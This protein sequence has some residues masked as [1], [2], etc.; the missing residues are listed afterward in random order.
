MRPLIGIVAR[1]NA[2]QENKFCINDEYRKSI[3]EH[4]GNV[5][6]ILPPSIINYKEIKTSDLPPLSKEEEDM[7]IKQISLCDGILLPG[8][9]KMLN[10]DFFILDYA[11]KNDIPI[12]GICL[13]MQ[14]MANYK[15]E[16]WNDVNPKDGINHNVTDGSLAHFV[17]IDK[18]SRLY[19]ILKE[20]KFMVNSLHNYHVLPN[21]YYKTVGFSEDGLIEAIEMSDKKFNIGVQWHPEKMN[22]DTSKRLISSFIDAARE[23]K[24]NLKINIHS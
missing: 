17:T 22:D 5:I 9:N 18:N 19:E 2:S 10:S 20:D 4:G 23:N 8:G 13:G 15:R 14:I 3:I 24:D 21:N 6:A 12:L 7:L 16:I 1:I 11:V